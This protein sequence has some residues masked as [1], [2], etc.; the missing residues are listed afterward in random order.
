MRKARPRRGQF[1]VKREGPVGVKR[2]SGDGKRMSNAAGSNQV[3]W[4]S[5]SVSL[6]MEDSKLG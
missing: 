4:I 6:V 3:S 5:R 1:E 2:T